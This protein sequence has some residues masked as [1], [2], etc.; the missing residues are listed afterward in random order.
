[1][2]DRGEILAPVTEPAAEAPSAAGSD[3]VVD[4]ALARV[5]TTL[6]DKWK[7]DAVL[8]VGGMAVVY[9]ATHRNGTRAA[10]KILHSELSLNA[11][12]R[13]RFLWEG[14]VANAVGH[15]GAVRV[16]DD[17][18]AEDG[19][20]FLVTELLEGETLEDR[21]VRLGGKLAEDEVLLAI[22]QMLDV[23]CV[24]HDHRIVH[25][26]LKP[27]NLFLTKSG[28]VKVLDFGIARLREPAKASSRL[29]QAGDAMGT[30]AYM[31]PEHARG[32]W[33]EV[34]EQSDIWASGALMFH[35]LTGLVVHEGRT[36]NEQLL[37][38]MTKPA[39]P[40]A[41]A[42]PHVS[43]QV[44]SL[45]DKAL[46]FEKKDRWPDARAM[47]EAIREAY[48][49]M[50]GAPIS[51]AT[52]LMVEGMAPDRSDR[53]IVRLRRAAARPPQPSAAERPVVLRTTLS[54][55][56]GRV[57]ITAAAL[58]VFVGGTA[59]SA[60]WVAH[61][62]GSSAAPGAAPSA[63]AAVLPVSAPPVATA[64][65]P[66]SETA[67]TVPS[68]PEISATDL[69]LAPEPPASASAP[70]VTVPARPAARSDCAP[71][72]VVDPSTGKKRWKLECL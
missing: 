53:S 39:V 36:V 49:E 71:P 26:D 62:G 41:T 20:P 3:P 47:R 12:A 57:W 6:R 35:L 31:A 25:R 51:N 17:D 24:A 22:D 65:A 14:H 9:A 4:Q 46:A 43:P 44:A 56:P 59:L 7:L 64:P 63:I 61:R 48:S 66:P 27:D 2:A 60:S 42:A 54:R 1:M 16:L 10:V 33:D 13:Q 40:L 69:P 58:T 67:Q 30:P 29:T 55:T 50:H 21:R 34:D 28:Q 11:L 68:P 70:R 52:P 37:A 23:L 8:G 15:P 19:S 18:V 5:G 38:A 32:L 72:Y 45:V